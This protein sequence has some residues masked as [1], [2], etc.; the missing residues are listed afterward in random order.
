MAQTT[1]TNFYF[2]TTPATQSNYSVN[3]YGANYS[4]STTYN[5]YFGNSSNGVASN[6]IIL[7]SLKINNKIYKPVTF[8]NGECYDKI[9]VN[10]VANSNV[11]D[12]DKQTLFFEFGSRNGNNAYFKSTYTDIQ[13][14]VNTRIL[15]RGGDNVFSNSGGATLNNIER[16]DLI[17]TGGNSSPNVN[18]SGFVINERGG[19]DDFAVAAIKSLDANDSVILLGNLLSVSRSYWG[20]SGQAIT[21]TVFQRT[22]ADTYMRPNQ[23]LSSQNIHGVFIS[24]ADLGIANNETIYGL[25][26]FPGD[27]NSSMD[28]VGLTNVPTNT[29]ASSN[30]AGGLDLMGG[31]GFFSSVDLNITDL[32][33]NISTPATSTPPNDYDHITLTVRADNNGPKPDN[34]ITVTTTIPN[35]YTYVSTNSGYP[36]TITVSGSTITWTLSSLDVGLSKSFSF[37]AEAQPTGNRQFTSNISGTLTDINSGN[38]SD[39]VDVPTASE[40]GNLPVEWLNVDLKKI[41]DEMLLS[42]VTASESNNDYFVVERSFDGRHFHGLKKIKAGGNSNTLKYYYFSDPVSGQPFVYYRIK[43]VDFDGRFS[44]SKTVYYSFIKKTE[45]LVIYPNPV[46]NFLMIENLE[47]GSQVHLFDVYGQEIQ[48]FK[49]DKADKIMDVSRMKKGIYYLI[50]NNSSGRSVRKFIKI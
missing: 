14:A 12:L 7:D 22:S 44:F 40:S 47:K 25:S 43:Q 49:A 11:T 42:W 31:G 50:M 26:I 27:V 4:T 45:P 29:T 8:Y 41:D 20:N 10:R 35:G 21:T 39:N 30:A 32:S 34:N 6:D 28:L 3:G 37:V 13:E 17:I 46:R 5:V 15:G 16:I 23:D 19:N 9:T 1:P 48:S 24:F 18:E 2:S 33:V 36:G 38:N